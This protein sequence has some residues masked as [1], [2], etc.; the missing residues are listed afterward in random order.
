MCFGPYTET[1]AKCG[2]TP[3]TMPVLDLK[4][5]QG[6]TSYIDFIDP[7]EIESGKVYQFVD[8]HGRPGFVF[9]MCSRSE[10][11]VKF[12]LSPFQRYSL[13]EKWSFGWGHSDN[14]LEWDISQYYRGI[15]EHWLSDSS[16]I[17]L[18]FL[19]SVLRGTHEE[20][21]MCVDKKQ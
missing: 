20:F 2:Y 14:R 10:P 4:G 18:D 9:L 15:S 13:G 5:R 17:R 1:L 12:T 6:L 21:M 7:S 8:C 16:T 3:E 11:H 19:E